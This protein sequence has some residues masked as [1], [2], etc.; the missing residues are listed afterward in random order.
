MIQG[1]WTKAFDTYGYKDL[2]RLLFVS[3]TASHQDAR[4]TRGSNWWRIDTQKSYRHT[5][6]T[7]CTPAHNHQWKPLS[8]YRCQNG[9]RPCLA[10]VW[11]D[12][13]HLLNEK[14]MRNYFNQI[15]FKVGFMWHLFNLIHWWT[16][17]FTEQKTIS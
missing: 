9:E 3:L 14:W 6:T 7:K 12:S 11:T 2:H 13:W 15:S 5:R 10:S 16:V 1:S 17:L 8:G 4:W